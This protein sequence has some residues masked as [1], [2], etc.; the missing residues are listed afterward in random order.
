MGASARL[1][2]GHADTIAE[3]GCPT[4]SLPAQPAGRVRED[5]RGA[6]GRA[7]DQPGARRHPR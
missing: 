7:R 6:R 4:G 1:D 2:H 5:R 3:L